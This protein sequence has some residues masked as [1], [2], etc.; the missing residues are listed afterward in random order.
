VGGIDQIQNIQN[1]LLIF[2]RNCPDYP[3]KNKNNLS[4]VSMHPRA[5]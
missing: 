2:D 5:S 3:Y 4:V 1:M